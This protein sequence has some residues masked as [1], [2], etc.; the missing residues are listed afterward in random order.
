MQQHQLKLNLDHDLLQK[1]VL[2]N[3]HRINGY[4][5]YT[6][7]NMRIGNNH[8]DYKSLN[9][10]LRLILLTCGSKQLSAA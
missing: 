4:A 9:G 1:Y 2:Q 8:C 7:E 6:E 10:N 3:L 5:F